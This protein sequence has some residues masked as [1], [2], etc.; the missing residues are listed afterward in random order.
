MRFIGRQIDPRWKDSGAQD[1]RSN[2]VDI[3]LKQAEVDPGRIVV[4]SFPRVPSSTICFMRRTAPVNRK[5]WS[6][7]IWRFFLSASSTNCSACANV[8]VNGFSTKTCLPFFSADSANSKWV[9]TGVTTA[10]A[11]TSGEE[12]TAWNSQVNSTFGKS[13]LARCSD[14]AVFIAYGDDFAAIY[15]VKIS[16]DTRS[17]IPVTDNR[18]SDHVCFVAFGSRVRPDP[19]VAGGCWTSKKEGFGQA[20]ALLVPN[21]TI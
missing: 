8:E 14:A 1:P 15:R 2:N 20:T 19:L 3:V 18:C 17:P 7:M 6:T 4:I 10:M 16:G 12:R 11:S 5:V 21:G 9:Q 13:R